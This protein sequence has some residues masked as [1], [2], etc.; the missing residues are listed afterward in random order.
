[1]NNNQ[2]RPMHG[3]GA[4]MGAEKPKEL[5]S[6]LKKLFISLK[7]YTF[8]I[9]IALILA[10]LG[11]ILS[12]VGPN[13]I[14]DLTNKIGEGLVIDTTEMQNVM[15]SITS[16]LS[17][18]MT[19]SLQQIIKPNLTQG[20]IT[21]ILSDDSISKDDKKIFNEI[22][23]TQDMTKISELSFNVQKIILPD[24]TY[25]DILITTSDKVVLLTSFYQLQNQEIDQTTFIK[26]MPESIL[27]SILTTSDIDGV[28]VS[29]TD[30]AQTLTILSNIDQNNA[31]AAYQKLDDLPTSVYNLI[32][33]KMDLTGIK[34][35]ALFLI[36]II[37]MQC[38]I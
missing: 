19:S 7:K 12:I 1:M 5:K 25:N 18:N 11:A 32:K 27:S 24:L 34:N 14:S 33:P 28:T 2:K 36:N 6:T 8:I 3:P 38:F 9:I 29:N 15:S 16:E 35:I 21:K 17:T 13:K 4:M 10:T 26:N 23:T 31:K 20:T 30:K 37:F 22:L